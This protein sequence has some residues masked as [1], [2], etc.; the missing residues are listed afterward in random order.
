MR[1]VIAQR[2]LE[3]KQ[4]IP[5]FYLSNDFEISELLAARNM[6][7]L[8]A[9]LNNEK[10]PLY[11]VSIN[12]MVIKA[13]AMAMQVV[14]EINTAWGGDHI[15][16]YSEVSIAIA[17]ALDDGLITPIIRNANHQ[18]LSQISNQVKELVKKAKNNALRP[19]EFQ[20]GSLSISNLGMYGIQQFNAIVNPPQA[21]ILAVGAV[22]EAPVVKSGTLAVGNVMNVTISCDH[23]VI[24]GAVAARF[25]QA[26]GQYLSN[27]ILMLA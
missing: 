18:T 17:V 13:T 23:R 11:K 12:D 16:S 20:G 21:C 24:D 10:Q 14:P 25:M 15:L 8:Q 6:I 22:V 26:L 1:R 7:N 2:L 9:P 27:P 4:N 5:H 19:E 3:S